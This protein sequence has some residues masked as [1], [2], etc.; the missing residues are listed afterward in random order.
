MEECARM[1]CDKQAM[2]MLTFAPQQAKAWLYDLEDPNPAG[3]IMLCRKHANATV[4]PMSWQLIDARDPAWPG[5]VE[6]AEVDSDTDAVDEI[7]SSS[8]A[9]PASPQPSPLADAM[10]PRRQAARPVVASTATD[11]SIAALRTAGVLTDPVVARDHRID[12]DMSLF[13]LPL[14]D[15]PAVTPHPDFR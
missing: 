3:G 12:A 5:P 9:L 11:P 15:A 6:N 1:N 14:S 10:A 2:A 7:T 13:Q 4:V 8:T